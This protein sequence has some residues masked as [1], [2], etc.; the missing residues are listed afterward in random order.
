MSSFPKIPYFPREGDSR[1]F[2]VGYD[3]FFP[4]SAAESYTRVEKPG[5]LIS[6]LN[7]YLPGLGFEAS[8]A[9]YSLN[10]YDG[11]TIQ[12]NLASPINI[13]KIIQ[14]E[15]GMQK[16]VQ[17]GFSHLYRTRSLSTLDI[18]NTAQ[19]TF[20]YYTITSTPIIVAIGQDLANIVPGSLFKDAFRYAI[21]SAIP[22]VAG[23][24]TIDC[25]HSYAD[26]VDVS[27]TIVQ[28]TGTL[29]PIGVNIIQFDSLSSAHTEFAVNPTAFPYSEVF[30][31][32]H[33]DS[34]RAEVS[35]TG[36]GAGGTGTVVI[37]FILRPRR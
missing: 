36:G 5:N 14:I 34:T 33:K 30:E 7:G 37:T 23:S 1:G 4:G 10:L 19:F 28:N 32:P 25:Y 18:I 8:T 12:L 24:A 9:F 29:D 3:I 11:V 26:V 21:Q 35:I 17:G 2:A 16:E 22:G 31:C 27:V 15:A 20:Q 13:G 6:V